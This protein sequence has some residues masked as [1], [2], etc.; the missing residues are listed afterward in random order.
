MAQKATNHCCKDSGSCF[1]SNLTRPLL[2]IIHLRFV[3]PVECVLCES[4]HPINY[5]NKLVGVLFS[6]L[7]LGGPFVYLLHTL[8]F[9]EFFLVV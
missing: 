2:L 9:I 5:S 4:L 1:K 7:S 6:M 8:G 3:Q